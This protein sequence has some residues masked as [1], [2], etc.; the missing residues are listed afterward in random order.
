MRARTLTLLVTLIALSGLYICALISDSTEI[1]VAISELGG[2]YTY[3]L[4]FLLL[5]IFVDA[6][7]A[8]NSLLMVLIAVSAS[9]LLKGFFKIP[10]PPGGRVV[11]EG[12]SFPSRHT[13][14]SSTFWSYLVFRVRDL[15]LMAVAL[16]T[17]LAIAHSRIAL[18]VHTYVDVY[19]GVMMGIMT[20]VLYGFISKHGRLRSYYT[21]LAL[22]YVISS[23]AGIVYGDFMMWKALGLLLA[24]SLYAHVR[25]H[26][27]LFKSLRLHCR[28]LCMASALAAVL[29]TMA[30]I[31][32]TGEALTVIKY[33][34]MGV[35][36]LYTPLLIAKRFNKLT[37][38]K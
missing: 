36:L 18:G 20:G 29:L 33:L 12:Y 28:V 3:V 21:T 19:A 16:L 15:L 35:A 7:L 14:T 5:Y 22:G 26:A 13:S 38:F 11:E 8:L 2:E 23:T 34:I 1:W 30:L 37:C 6:D 17:V 24:L 25:S 9:G 4:L 27:H 31:P 10:R 32:S